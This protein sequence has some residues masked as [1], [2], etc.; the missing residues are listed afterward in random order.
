M[1]QISYSPISKINSGTTHYESIVGDNDSGKSSIGITFE[2]IGY[3][4]VY[5][6][7]PSAANIFRCLGTIEPGQ[8]PI[9]LDEADKIDKS[10]EMMA[11]LK[12]GYQLNGKVPKINTNI[13]R[14]EFFCTYGFKLIIAEKSM[15]LIEAKGVHDRTFSFTAYSGDSA[16]DIK[17][18]LNPQGNRECQKRLKE[19]IS[20]RKL[21]II[22]RL[23]HFKDA[24]IDIDIGLRRR[25]RELVKPILQ[26][27]CNAEPQI[28]REIAST[29][30]GFLKAKQ[31]R[32]ENTIE[33]ALYPIITNLISEHRSRELQ[34]SQIWGTIIGGNIID[35]YYDERKPNEFQTGDYGTIYRNSITNTICDKFG[36]QK[37]HK[38]K[39]SVLIFDTGKLLRMAKSYGSEPK[40][41]LKITEDDGPD[42]SDGSDDF[43]KEVTTFKE[44]HDAE[45]TKNG[46]NS[47]NIS[48]ENSTNNVNNMMQENERS[49]SI[50]IKPS[51]PSA[52]I[53]STAIVSVERFFNDVAD[54]PY[55]PLP[56]HSLEQS[57]CYPIIGRN[58]N[59]S[60]FCRLHPEVKNVNLESV[61]HHCKYKDPAYHKSEILRL[62]LS[63]P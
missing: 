41:Q 43:S 19:L 20:F 13:L 27:F 7:D 28:Q 5:M 30:E 44:N 49:S 32:R 52:S 54:L 61:E 37:I 10:P 59:R 15:S 51:E 1:Q 17:E 45:V 50:V 40:I 21:L 4:P 12:T 23:V 24:V 58:N 14:Q 48:E 60:Y 53:E 34:A 11:I 29:L 8:C 56:E 25:N 16:F 63:K 57:P 33:A 39:G 62:T 42:G 35:G 26:L 22:Y 3:R 9:I 55:Q 46:S 38:E 18:T 31:A 6:T 47:L 36:A 2:A